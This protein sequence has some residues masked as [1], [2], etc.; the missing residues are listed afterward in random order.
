MLVK[1]VIWNIALFMSGDSC[2]I[3]HSDFAFVFMH[4][5]HSLLVWRHVTGCC[6]VCNPHIGIF[7]EF[8]A[9]GESLI[10]IVDWH[11]G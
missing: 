11:E 2:P 6:T 9:V 4:I 3:A 10:E 5:H 8:H 1:N 7:E